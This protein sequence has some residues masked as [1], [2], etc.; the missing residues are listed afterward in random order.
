LVDHP[1]FGLHGHYGTIFATF[2][3]VPTH[4]VSFENV[5]IKNVQ[6]ASTLIEASTNNHC[7]SLKITIF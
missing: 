4:Y 1:S 3:L 6:I 7:H 5:K 2:N